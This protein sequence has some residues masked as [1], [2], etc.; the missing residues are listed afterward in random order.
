MPNESNKNALVEAGCA[1]WFND[2][3]HGRS[4]FPQEIQR[5]IKRRAEKEYRMWLANLTDKDN[6]EVTDDEMVSVFERFLF[7]EGLKLIGKD[8][9]DLVLTLHYPL[10]PRVGDLVKDELSG[11]SRV[12]ERRLAA[13][14]NNKPSMVVILQAAESG[15]TW[16]TEFML[17]P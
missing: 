16:Q 2:N 11:E 1:F 17:P 15:E 4:P 5:E 9:P 6:E 14:V 3:E 12:I 8:D 13:K 7:A 10:M